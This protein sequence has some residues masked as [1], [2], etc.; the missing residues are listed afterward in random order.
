MLSTTRAVPPSVCC[1]LLHCSPAVD[2]R[3]CAFA[4]LVWATSLSPRGAL[5]ASPKLLRFGGGDNSGRRQCENRSS[6]NISAAAQRPPPPS[7]N[8]FISQYCP[9]LDSRLERAAEETWAIPNLRLMTAC[10]FL[11]VYVFRDAEQLSNAPSPK[12]FSEFFNVH[13]LRSP[14]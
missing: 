13:Q 12:A 3:A 10:V 7:F 6:I 9:H 11:E 8:G 2:A 14:T 5:A 1:K 4:S